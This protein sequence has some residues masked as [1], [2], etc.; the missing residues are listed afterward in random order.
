MSSKSDV[1]A[2]KPQKKSRVLVTFF[3]LVAAFL[4]GAAFRTHGQLP[5]Y[6]PG[7]RAETKKYTDFSSFYPFYR[8]E[9]SDTTNHF[10]H[11]VGTTIVVALILLR[12]RYLLAFIIALALGTS[13]IP[14]P[15]F[16]RVTAPLLFFWLIREGRSP[17]SHIFRAFVACASWRFFVR[18]QQSLF[19]G[20]MVCEVT[21]ALPNGFVEFGIMISSYILVNY[22]LVGRSGVEV[23]LVGYGLAW[24]RLF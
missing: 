20:Y 3:V 2:T 11:V 8:K 12:P 15:F 9:H 22:I 23:L 17:S 1:K 14:P 19:Q 7:P 6:P 13:L 4:V 18:S 5:K 21:S 16:S 10:L 24:V